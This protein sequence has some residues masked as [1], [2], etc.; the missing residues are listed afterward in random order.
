MDWK[1]L[2]STLLD[3]NSCQWVPIGFFHSILQGKPVCLVTGVF[4]PLSSSGSQLLPSDLLGSQECR[5]RWWLLRGAADRPGGPGVACDIELGLERKESKVM[6]AKQTWP[7]RSEVELQ[8]L[9]LVI[10]HG[11]I[12]FSSLPCQGVA[13]RMPSWNLRGQLD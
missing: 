6:R 7:E 8:K 3:W 11:L 12:G 9:S 10:R 13:Q 2:G 4:Y 1:L 5:W